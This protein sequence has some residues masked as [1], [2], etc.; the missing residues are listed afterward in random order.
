MS[1]MITMTVRQENLEQQK[2]HLLM[3]KSYNLAKSISVFYA[4]I[5][6]KECAS[7]FM[8]LKCCKVINQLHTTTTV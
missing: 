8:T 2:L 7:F 6:Y 4:E 5:Y 3:G 1:G